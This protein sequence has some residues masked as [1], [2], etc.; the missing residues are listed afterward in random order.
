MCQGM[1]RGLLGNQVQCVWKDRSG[2]E[3]LR[4]VLAEFKAL[5]CKAEAYSNGFIHACIQQTLLEHL[6]YAKNYSRD[7]GYCDNTEKSIYSTGT[8]YHGERIRQQTKHHHVF[9]LSLLMTAWHSSMQ[10]QLCWLNCGLED[11]LWKG[12]PHKV[13][14]VL[15]VGW[16]LCQ[17]WKLEV[18]VLLLE[19][20][21]FS[22]LVEL[23]H[24]MAAESS[25][26]ISRE[27]GGSVWY[28]D[29]LAW[30]FY[31][32]VSPPPQ[33]HACCDSR[34]GNINLIA[35]WKEYQRKDI[36][37]RALGMKDIVSSIF[38]KYKLFHKMMTS[39]NSVSLSLQI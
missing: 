1:C 10:W 17:S 25:M 11:P 20:C 38:G 23:P 24:S 33:S 16:Q 22:W 27:P 19:S 37:L 14:V 18:W 13:K 34:G 15:A 4:W 2:G 26:G 21:I 12:L 32:L 8:S 5:I 29:D 30:S 31:E 9:G 36:E 39:C 6:L 28:C 3:K 7:G 35:W